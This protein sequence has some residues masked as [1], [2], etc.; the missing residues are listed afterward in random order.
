M[1][2]KIVAMLAAIVLVCFA[3]TTVQATNWTNEGEDNLWQNPANW[4]D[5]VPTGQNTWVDLDGDDYALIG[6]GVDASVNNIR[7]GDGSG[8]SGHLVVDGGSI[9]GTGGD[10]TQARVFI[11]GRNGGAG[12]MDVTNGTIDQWHNIFIGHSGGG[13]GEI[14]IDGSDTDW[15][16]QR[17]VIGD[18]AGTTGVLNMS[19]GL[20]RST[21]SAANVVGGG[22]NATLNMSGGTIDFNQILRIGI[23][24]DDGNVNLDG[25]LII[26][27]GE[28]GTEDAIDM[29]DN[30]IVN[31]TDGELRLAG[32]W[33]DDVGDWVSAEKMSGFGVFSM[34]NIIVDYDGDFTSI[35]A[36]PEPA[37]IALLGLGSSLVMLK[38]RRA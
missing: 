24:G 37:T 12:R 16:Y 27:R 32:D 13:T 30:A 7:M 9:A 35:T 4:D 18:E 22:G 17:L 31:I 23:G 6:S 5:G 21:G 26:G 34:D 33:Q 25:G 8:K 36:I 29:G 1:K 14:N 38:R 19:D 28:E 20:F 3:A 2:T 15:E 11:L 10:G